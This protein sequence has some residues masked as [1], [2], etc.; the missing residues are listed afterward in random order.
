MKSNICTW[1]KKCSAAQISVSAA[2]MRIAY[3]FLDCLYVKRLRVLQQGQRLIRNKP[4]LGSGG[5][6][7]ATYSPSLRPTISS[8][9][10]TSTYVLPLCT[11]KRRPTK[12]GRMVA[13]RFV[14]RIGGVFGGGGRVRGR[15][16]LDAIGRSV[17]N[18]VFMSCSGINARRGLSSFVE[19]YVRNDVGA[20]RRC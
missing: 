10:W 16:R 8:V 6:T 18:S 14:V 20:W 5:K 9:I 11:A 4:G 3:L 19:G 17:F 2:I 12:F 13:A 1:C 15:A 7:Y